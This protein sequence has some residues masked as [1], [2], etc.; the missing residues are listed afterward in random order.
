MPDAGATPIVALPADRHYTPHAQ[1]L[2]PRHSEAGLRLER[3]VWSRGD[4][5]CS[6][7]V[8]PAV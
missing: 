2:Y 3:Q 1:Q 6:C 8:Y 5:V 4:G 7:S